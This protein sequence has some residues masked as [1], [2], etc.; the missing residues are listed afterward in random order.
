MPDC[1]RC[2]SAG[3][4]MYSASREDRYSVDNDS[5]VRVC[6]GCY[7]YYTW[8]C[9][10]CERT[11]LDGC[12]CPCGVRYRRAI[13]DYSERV[14]PGRDLDPKTLYYGVELEVET[15]TNPE[16]LV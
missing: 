2:R 10:E 4:E 6:R 14:R 5:P 12:S 8:Q 16:K 15:C 7:E 9:W 1:D 11:V 13:R 3:S